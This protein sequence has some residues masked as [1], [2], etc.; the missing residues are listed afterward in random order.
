MILVTGATG[1]VGSEVVKQLVAGRRPVRA[2]VRAPEPRGWPEGVGIAIGDLDRPES[3][4]DALAGVRGV[5][6]LGGHRDMPGVL[7]AIRRAGVARVVLLSSRSVEGGD[8]A[9]A[10]VEMWL[11]SEAAV[12]DAG[13]PWTILHPSG[14]MSNALRWLPQLRAG[15]RVRIPFAGVPIAAIDPEDIAAVAARA[16]DDE[17]TVGRVLT[18]SGPEALLPAEQLRILGA[19]LGRDLRA[20]PLSDAEA[21][22][23]LSGAFPPRFVDAFF[24]FFAQGEFNDARVVPTV[25][26]LTGRAPRTFAAWAHAHAAAFR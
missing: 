5:F 14:F 11:T 24:G 22:V 19:E 3:L 21:R 25:Q 2:L 12:K 18:L 20:Q 26:E 8:P 6:L 15:D 1:Q 17:R 16:F 13:V 4:E 7:A 23:E 10:V 9:N